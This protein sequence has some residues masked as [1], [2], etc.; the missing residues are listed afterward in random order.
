M[1]TKLA[2]RINT[3]RKAAEEVHGVIHEARGILDGARLPADV[4]Y[5][6]MDEHVWTVIE[7]RLGW[8]LS[9]YRNNFREYHQLPREN[10]P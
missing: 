3:S 6:L 10:A 9:T 2:D 7:D 1:R 5:E 8:D 4:Q